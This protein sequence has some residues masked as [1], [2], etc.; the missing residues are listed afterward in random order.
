MS[1]VLNMIGKFKVYFSAPDGLS[2]WQKVVVL[3][4]VGHTVISQS[5]R[6]YLVAKVVHDYSADT[7][8]VK[9]ELE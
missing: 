5:G 4:S 1:E 7:I 6:R 9:L 2:F 3:P 8:M